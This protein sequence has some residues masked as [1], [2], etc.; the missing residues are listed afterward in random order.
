MGTLLGRIHMGWILIPIPT[1]MAPVCIYYI[2]FHVPC[3]SMSW[4]CP[5]TLRVYT[6]HVWVCCVIIAH[7]YYSLYVEARA[8]YEWMPTVLADKK[9]SPSS[10]RL[11]SLP[12]ILCLNPSLH[13][14]LVPLLHIHAT[15]PYLV[16]PRVCMFKISM[17]FKFLTWI[18]LNQLI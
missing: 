1:C 6:H 13:C 14:L 9:L 15:H 5:C 10:L 11:T 16:G 7:P 18:Y 3:S 4:I 2:C 17:W 8:A 12:K